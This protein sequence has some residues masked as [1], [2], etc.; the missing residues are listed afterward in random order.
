MT[1]K[2]DP[3]KLDDAVQLYLSTKS[4]K[5]VQTKFGISRSVLYRELRSRGIETPG[6]RIALD[7]P[8]LRR[9]YVDERVSELEIANRYGIGRIVVRRRL[10]ELGIQPR[11]SKEAQ[12]IRMSRTTAEERL[13][14][15][16]AAHEAVRG[17]KRTWESRCKLSAD[18]ERRP[19]TTPRSSGEEKVGR[20]LNELGLDPTPQ[21]AIG[22]YNLDFA[23]GS[24]AVEVLGGTWHAHKPIHRSRTPYILNQGWSLV[25][26]WDC[27]GSRL[28]RGCANY[29]ASLV[30]ESRRNPS[31]VGEYRVI[32]GNGEL[33][34]RGRVEDDSFTLVQPSIRG[35]GTRP[36]D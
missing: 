3:V 20:W 2:T 34:A 6:T 33:L 29:V 22:A 15:T 7:L 31:L 35:L 26:I 13:E 5:Q 27:R 32:R 8:E 25:F 11:S 10:V 4:P 16:A 23:I 30:E 19:H 28:T 1:C 36:G 17:S 18:R 14:L 24:V 21:K 9:L 12:E